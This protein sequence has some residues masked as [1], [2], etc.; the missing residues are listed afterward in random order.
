M[1]GLVR[2]TDYGISASLPLHK[3]HVALYMFSLQLTFEIFMSLCLS[4][5]EPVWH[6]TC[7]RLIVISVS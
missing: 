1:G 4:F 6:F 7:K 5:H 3:F 2:G